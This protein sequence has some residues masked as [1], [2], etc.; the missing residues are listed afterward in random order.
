VNTL[1]YDRIYLIYVATLKYDGIYLTSVKTV[2]YDTNAIDVKI[3]RVLTGF[4]IG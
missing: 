4:L 2:E 3:E 1:E